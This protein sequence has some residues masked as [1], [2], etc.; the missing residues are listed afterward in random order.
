MILFYKGKEIE[1]PFKRKTGAV[2][3]A[4]IEC[5]N[6]L[7]EDPL[8][9]E[10]Q[11]LL[12]KALADTDNIEEASHGKN[13]DS[14]TALQ[15]GMLSKKLK[16]AKISKQND[17]VNYKAMQL[18]LD[19]SAIKFPEGINK[20]EFTVD[21]SKEMK[22]DFTEFWNEQDITEVYKEVESFRQSLGI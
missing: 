19:I 20:D 7:Q 16:D 2:K 11:D 18:I 17:I 5:L 3:F 12:K 1:V 15:F 14:L 10:Q 6:K 9:K 21:F 13:I 22:D 8:E 4:L